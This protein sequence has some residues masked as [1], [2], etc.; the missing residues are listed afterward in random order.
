[1]NKTI[2]FAMVAIVAIAGSLTFCGKNVASSIELIVPRDTIYINDTV[3]TFEEYDVTDFTNTSIKMYQ[4]TNTEEEILEMLQ[5]SWKVAPRG[6]SGLVPHTHT[7]EEI[8][9]ML[10]SSWKV[11]SFGGHGRMLTEPI[12]LQL[13]KPLRLNESAVYGNETNN[14][15]FIYRRK[16]P[17]M[18]M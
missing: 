5:S 9:E 17:R 1:M 6:E 12:S 2:I 13:S 7:E 10:Q 11:Y 16:A 3:V 15:I 8:L 4:Q 14:D 18:G